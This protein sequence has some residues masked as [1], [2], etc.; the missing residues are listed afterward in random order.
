MILT[1]AKIKQI[2]REELIALLEDED[3]DFPP[4]PPEARMSMLGRLKGEPGKPE[5][6]YGEAAAATQKA[7]KAIADRFRLSTEDVGRILTQVQNQYQGR[8]F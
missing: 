6:K 3:S 1:E 8:E 4:I 2:I 7:V 5:N